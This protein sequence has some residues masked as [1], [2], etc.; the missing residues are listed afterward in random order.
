MIYAVPQQ[1]SRG[2]TGCSGSQAGPADCWFQL[3]IAV[4]DSLKGISASMSTK[5]LRLIR[6]RL[7]RL[8]VTLAGGRVGSEKQHFLDGGQKS[9]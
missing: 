6:R 7:L 2:V 1:S 5:L 3:L 9:F 4:F 8:I